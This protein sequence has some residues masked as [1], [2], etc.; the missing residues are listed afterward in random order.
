LHDDKK[1]KLGF[2][3]VVNSTFGFNVAE[4]AALRFGGAGFAYA[5]I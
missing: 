5:R 3:F 4:A 2:D 1:D